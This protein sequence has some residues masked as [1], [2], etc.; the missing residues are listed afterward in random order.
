MTVWFTS[1][2]HIGHKFVAGARRVGSYDAVDRDAVTPEIVQ[3][4]NDL[5]ASKWDAVVKKDDIVWVVGDL[6][7]GGYIQEGLDWIR[8]RPG[9]KHLVVG[10]HDKA[11]PMNTDSAKYQEVFL[12][13][14]EASVGKPRPFKSVQMAARRSV[15]VRGEK[16][17]VMLSHF[18]FTEDHSPEARYMKWRLRDE[19]EYL[20]HGHTHSTERFNGKEIHVGV[21]A[22]DFAPVSLETITEYIITTHK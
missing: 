18:P 15:K 10:N 11:H 22:W 16:V 4:H 17:N 20:I 14:D 6:T 13:I 1:D 5:V 3:D 2:L 21:D 7:G 12:G 9:T 19:G 8:A